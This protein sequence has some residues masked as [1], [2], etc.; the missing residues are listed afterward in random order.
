MPRGKNEKASGIYSGHRAMVPILTVLLAVDTIATL[1]LDAAA[2][3]KGY[4]G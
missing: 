1:P 4:V 2:M 3:Q